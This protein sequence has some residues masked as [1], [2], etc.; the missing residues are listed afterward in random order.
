MTSERCGHHLAVGYQRAPTRGSI[1]EIGSVPPEEP[2]R[3]AED[4]SS[5]HVEIAGSLPDDVGCDD[6]LL[7]GY[8]DRSAERS[9][10]TSMTKADLYQMAQDIDIE[11]RADMTKA[12]LIT[13]I[14]SAG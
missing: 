5:E 13:A 9:A 10:L 3:G 2:D 8:V 6:E 11:G 14:N 1:T 4:R 12:Q 7:A